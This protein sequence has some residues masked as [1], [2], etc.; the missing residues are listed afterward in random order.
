MIALNNVILSNR[1][2]CVRQATRGATTSHRLIATLHLVRAR[3]LARIVA[4][5]RTRLKIWNFRKFKFVFWIFLLVRRPPLPVQHQ[6]L[7]HRQYNPLLLLLLASL[8]VHILFIFKLF[9]FVFFHLLNIQYLFYF[10]Q[11]CQAHMD[12]CWK[13]CG[14]P[15]FFAYRVWKNNFFFRFLETKLFKTN[16]DR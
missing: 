2:S 13:E 11:F 15:E 1:L 14:K 9:S 16:F 5:Q 6:R 12:K 4:R 10:F 8:Y 3:S 7:L